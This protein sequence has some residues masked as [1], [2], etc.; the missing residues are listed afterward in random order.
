[1]AAGSPRRR[2]G[3]TKAPVVAVRPPENLAEAG[4]VT[5][6]GTYDG[7]HFDRLSF[8]QASLQGSTFQECRFDGVSM[9]DAQLRG[10]RFLES[11]FSRL[12]APVFNAPRAAFRDVLLEGT[13]WGSARLNESS[14]TSVHMDGGKLDYLDLRDS[15]LENVL[16]SDCIIEELDLAGATANRVAFQRCRIGSLDPT[17]AS[18]RDVDLR[19]TQLRSLARLDGLSGATIDENQLMELAPLLAAYVGLRIEERPAD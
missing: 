11:S 19:S 6:P 3:G 15:R 5:S 4:A 8:D 17:G 1:M 16:F 2:T 18:L 10:V 12:Y 9:H 14:W 13:R 7:Q